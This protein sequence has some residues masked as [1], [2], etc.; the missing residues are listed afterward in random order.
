MS[1]RLST[2][3]LDTMAGVYAPPKRYRLGKGGG[4]GNTSKAGGTVL[5]LAV[6]AMF[7]KPKAGS[8]AARPGLQAK[9]AFGGSS[10][11]AASRRAVSTMERTAR[12][13]PEVVVRITGRQHGGGHV[14]ANFS[15]ISRLG[16]GADEELSLYTSDGDVIRDGREMQ[17][18][19]QDWH[20]WEMGDDA[21][22][23][24]ATSISIIL[25]MP[26][27]TDPERLKEAA[28]DFARE[29]FAN[30]VVGGFAACRSRSPSCPPN[31]RAPRP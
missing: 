9:A 3:T 10:Y 28:L 12:R 20:E 21:R 7:P 4:K 29:E 22:R 2:G 15:Y 14:L 5:G 31:I 8:A 26:S 6:A 19:A 11:A 18:L 17:T 13:A 23:K 25:S 1:F 30:R 16:H 24:G 27:G